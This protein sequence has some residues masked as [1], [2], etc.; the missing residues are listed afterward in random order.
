[1]EAWSRALGV[2]CSHCHVEGDFTSVE[3]PTLEFARRM[4]KMV[5]GL[6]AGRLK[7]LVGLRAG[8]VTGAPLAPPACHASR[9]R[10]LRRVN[11]RIFTG[12]SRAAVPC[13]E[14]VLGI[15]G[16]R[17]FALSRAWKLGERLQSSPRH[18][19]DNGWPVRRAPNLLHQGAHAA[20]PMLH[21]PP[22]CSEAAALESAARLW[23][24][25]CDATSKDGLTAFCPCQFLS[26]RPL[27]SRAPRLSVMTIDRHTSETK[28][29]RGVQQNQDRAAPSFRCKTGDAE[30]LVERGKRRGVIA[31]SRLDLGQR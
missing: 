1:M 20:V 10:R 11:K 8:P 22:R 23:L 4:S 14:R 26:A 27:S 18:R 9:G 19:P 3:K 2:S 5:D 17:L 15:A 24:S 25:S 30:H 12:D 16:C 31:E 21:V 7:S 13:H 29:E 6:S 28:G